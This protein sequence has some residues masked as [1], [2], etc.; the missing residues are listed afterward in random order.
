MT[1]ARVFT[2]LDL[3]LP[4]ANVEEVRSSSGTLLGFSI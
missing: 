4:R 1:L 3:E 2:G